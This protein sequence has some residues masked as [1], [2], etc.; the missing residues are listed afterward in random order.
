M[1]RSGQGFSAHELISSLTLLKKHVWTYTRTRGVWQRPIDVY[2]VLELNRR[3]ALFF[4]R[5][6]YHATLGFE[7]GL[8]GQDTGD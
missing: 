7:A 1:E 6:I 5:A 8:R 4:D 2:R 3:I